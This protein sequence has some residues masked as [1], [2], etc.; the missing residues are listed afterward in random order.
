MEYEFDNNNVKN[1]I[2]E[3]LAEVYICSYWLNK[4]R[5]SYNVLTYYYIVHMYVLSS[6]Y[7]RFIVLRFRQRIRY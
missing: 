7:H 3:L 2:G 6:C 4:L 5:V 1:K